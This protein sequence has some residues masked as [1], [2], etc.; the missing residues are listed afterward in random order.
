MA[1]N[2]NLEHGLQDASCIVRSWIDA[3][4]LYQIRQLARNEWTA[5][6]GDSG[7]LRLAIAMATLGISL[8]HY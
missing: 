5:S 8:W 1:A 4:S 2:T 6:R 3:F 7:V